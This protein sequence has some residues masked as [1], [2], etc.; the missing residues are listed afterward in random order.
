[1]RRRR[2]SRSAAVTRRR[3][4]AGMG[5]APKQGVRRLYRPFGISETKIYNQSPIRIISARAYFLDYQATDGGGN[6]WSNGQGVNSPLSSV[7]NATNRQPAAD[8]FFGNS[9]ALS[10][11]AGAV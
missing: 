6:V 5:G 4:G 2:R 3:A 7:T 1:M 11:L 10:P 9:G 8:D